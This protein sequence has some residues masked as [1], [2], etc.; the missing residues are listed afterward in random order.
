MPLS[1]T[2]RVIGADF[3][4]SWRSGAS[5]EGFGQARSASAK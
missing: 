1:A 2:V 4:L 5:G 3:T